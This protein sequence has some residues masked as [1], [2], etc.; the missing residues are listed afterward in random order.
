MMAAVSLQGWPS[1]EVEMTLINFVVVTMMVQRP[2]FQPFDASTTRLVRRP[3]GP[4]VA[5][6]ENG[7]R[8]V[9]IAEID[10]GLQQDEKETVDFSRGGAPSGRRITPP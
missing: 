3:T 7:L 8:P 1:D 4:R 9:P 10:P 2:V 5:R 6:P